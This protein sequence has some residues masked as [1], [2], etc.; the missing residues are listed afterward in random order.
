MNETYILKV[1]D[2]LGNVRATMNVIS[3]EQGLAI[4]ELETP[5]PLGKYQLKLYDSDNTLIFIQLFR[6]IG[7]ARVAPV[8]IMIVANVQ[9]EYPGTGPLHV[10]ALDATGP[11]TLI[12]QAEPFTKVHAYFVE[13]NTIH[14]LS[15][16]ANAHGVFTLP[17]LQ[18]EQTLYLFQRSADGV[19]SEHIMMTYTLAALQKRPPSPI[20][21]TTVL[22][23]IFLLILAFSFA[24]VRLRR[25]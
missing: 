22:F 14:I 6:I 23:G 11:V 5:L 25:K 2:A 21:R 10:G 13:R 3:N 24:G 7:P 1:I 20:S 4:V 19:L 15:V 8:K 18:G 17:L 16:L 9:V 12:G